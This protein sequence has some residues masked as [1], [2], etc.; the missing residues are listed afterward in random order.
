M[1][2]N[3]KTC[4]LKFDSYLGAFER[5]YEGNS[6]LIRRGDHGPLVHPGQGNPYA[7]PMDDHV[8]MLNLMTCGTRLPYGTRNQYEALALNI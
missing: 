3:F 6:D 1:S 8:G 5:R 4:F 2:P 7:Q